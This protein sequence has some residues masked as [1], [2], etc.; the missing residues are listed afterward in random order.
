[1]SSL[2]P[3]L[4]ST[5]VG[6]SL[7]I[8][9]TGLV[10]I[11]KWKG[12][13]SLPYPPGPP[14]DPIIGNA[15][16]MATDELASVF[17]DWGKKYGDVNYATLIGQPYIVLNSYQAAR[18]LLEKRSGIYSN[19]PPMVM[20][21]EMMGWGEVLMHQEL[22]PRFRKHRRIVQEILSTKHISQYAQIQRKEAYSTLVDLGNTPD[23]L[24]KHL[25]RILLDGVF[26]A[27]GTI[28]NIT[29]GY[30]VK[31]CDDPLVLLADECMTATMGAIGLGSLLCDLIPALK[32]WPTWAPFS[33]FKKHTVYTRSLVERFYHEPFQW[34]KTRMAEGAVKQCITVDLMET[35]RTQS[36]P[37]RPSETIDST[38][39]LHISSALY[40]AASETTAAVLEA[41]FLA[42]LHHPEVFSKMQEEIDQKTGKERLV[43][44]DDRDSLPYFECVMRE[45]LRWGCP[46]PLGA[47]HQ[48]TENDIYKGYSMPKDATVMFNVFAMTRNEE[49]YPEPEKFMP[50]RFWGKLDTE[51][52]RQVNA[53]FGFGRRV[54]PGK[55]FAEASIFFVMSN[56]VASMDFTKAVDEAG[57]PIT[58]PV[59]F[60]KTL[61]RYVNGTG[62]VG[63]PY[64]SNLLDTS[65]RSSSSCNTVLKRRGFSSSKQTSSTTKL[66]HDSSFWPTWVFAH[67][68]SE[69][70]TM[71][72]RIL[73]FFPRT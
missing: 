28:L 29:Y 27:A 51:A 31:D 9:V 19:R 67:I 66:V 18:D 57:V 8:A 54:C 73:T 65:Y 62:V 47:P 72:R 48:L 33:G 60:T 10:A 24:I 39:I 13:R 16:A 1:M 56:I 34:L 7:A 64:L 55:A 45:V 23:D 38:D 14:P 70:N 69:C 17:A 61:V 26:T 40:A 41:F 2:S 58:P 25:K 32:H 5:T 22:G 37:H 63:K 43:D 53:V 20:L 12:S 30:T 49:L 44:F 35:M 36:G 52:A 6:I 21:S 3:L 11:S 42:L 4:D 15:R 71:S 59:E 68:V 46:A 50:E